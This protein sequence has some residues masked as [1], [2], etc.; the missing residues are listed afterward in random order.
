MKNELFKVV[1]KENDLLD[2]YVCVIDVNQDILIVEELLLEGTTVKPSVALKKESVQKLDNVPL[3][4]KAAHAVWKNNILSNEVNSKQKEK[5]IEL[6]SQ[7]YSV[8]KNVLMQIIMELEEG[9]FL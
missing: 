8:D 9:S 1:E 5:I 6:L 3:P 7:K 4:W 2:K